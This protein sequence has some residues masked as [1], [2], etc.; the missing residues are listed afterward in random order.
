MHKKDH[1]HKF[2]MLKTFIVLLRA[3]GWLVLVGGLAGAI[4]AMIAPELIDQLG[5]LNIYHSAWLL[6]LVI[7]IGAVVYAMIFFALAEAIGAF[8]SVEGN[9]RKLRELLDKK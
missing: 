3:L 1:K 2:P 5:L 4:E 9:M 6:A 8:L 7:L